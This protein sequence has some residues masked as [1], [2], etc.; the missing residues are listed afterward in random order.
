MHIILLKN[1]LFCRQNALLKNHLFCMLESLPAEFI[2]AHA[3]TL[4]ERT[5]H[6]FEA[7]SQ[8]WVFQFL[9]EIWNPPFRD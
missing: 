1:A 5:E 2:Q 4:T 7:V 3:G 9:L 6:V 8:D